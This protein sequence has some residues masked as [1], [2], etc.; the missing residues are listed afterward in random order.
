MTEEQAYQELVF[1][2]QEDLQ[3]QQEIYNEEKESEYYEPDAHSCSMHRD[4]Y[5]YCEIC[6]AAVP[7]SMAYFDLYGGE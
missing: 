1:D 4:L 5:G 6:G 2:K 3:L 7:G